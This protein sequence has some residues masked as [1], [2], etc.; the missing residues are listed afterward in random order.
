MAASLPSLSAN[1]RVS[2]F[3]GTGSGKSV[4]AHYLY[5][6]IPE[7]RGWWKVIIDVTNSI[8]DPFALPLLPY[9]QIPWDKGW[10]FHFVPD[11]M[12]D[13]EAQVN[14][15]YLE[16]FRHGLVTIWLDEGNE[17]S[18][19]HHTVRAVR[20]VNLQG[21][22]NL[23]GQIMATP[24]PADISVSFFSQAQLV[25]VFNLATENDRKRVAGNFGMSLAEFDEE[26]FAL[27]QYGYL[28]Y[29]VTTHRLWRMPPL[30]KDIVNRLTAVSS[31]SR[32]VSAA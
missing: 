20:T 32:N 14:F 4:F 8:D 1:D 17:V 31:V 10:N 22:K 28:M 23:T 25:I 3:G 19:A 13:L 5:R 7:N 21:R 24:R 30:P 29:E 26:M 11:L 12:G 2:I 9:Q 15:V 16:C 18:T 27:P 6:R